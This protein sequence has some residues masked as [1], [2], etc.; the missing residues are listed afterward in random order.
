MTDKE[1][2]V[3]LFDE[4]KLPL[5]EPIFNLSDGYSGFSILNGAAYVI[6]NSDGKVEDYHGGYE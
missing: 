2:F 4:L 1:K 3:A 6:F 5:S